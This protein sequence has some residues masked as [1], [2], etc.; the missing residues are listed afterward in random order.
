VFHA[1]G[2]NRTADVHRFA[3]LMQIGS[4][5]GRSTVIA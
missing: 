5:Y 3:N 2:E 4:I 1:A